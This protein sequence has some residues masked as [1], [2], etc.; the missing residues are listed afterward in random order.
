ML[1]RISMWADWRDVEGWR[2][3]A[4]QRE[5][6]EWRADIEVSRAADLLREDT[7]VER[8]A[9]RRCEHKVVR[10]LGG[11]E[12]GGG[13]DVLGGGGVGEDTRSEATSGAA[14][15]GGAADATGAGSD[16]EGTPL[17]FCS[18]PSPLSVG[19]SG[20]AG[21]KSTCSS[22]DIIRLKGFVLVRFIC[23]GIITRGGIFWIR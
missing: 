15:G 14:A 19:S 16:T 1:E 20:V 8:Q 7:E 17:V 12:A 22:S 10:K 18:A 3:W 13:E 4:V 21:S 23:G 2:R 6:A 5:T 9:V 11:G